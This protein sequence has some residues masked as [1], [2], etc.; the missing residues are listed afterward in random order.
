MFATLLGEKNSKDE[1]L[2]GLLSIREPYVPF[3]ASQKDTINLNEF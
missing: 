3:T 2:K 1:D